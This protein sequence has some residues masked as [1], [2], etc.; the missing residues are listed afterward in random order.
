[1]DNHYADRRKW[2]HQRLKVLPGVRS[3]E[4]D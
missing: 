2:G 4:Q 1:V 3:A